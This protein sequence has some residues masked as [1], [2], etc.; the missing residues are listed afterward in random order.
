MVLR[1]AVAC[2]VLGSVLACAGQVRRFPLADPVWVDNDSRVFSDEPG[3]YY[4]G[5]IADGADQIIFRPLAYAWTFE[6]E[7]DAWN[8]NAVDEVPNSAWFTNRIGMFSM[9][10]EEA[11]RGACQDTP[12]LSPSQAP[13]V[14]T[15]A[16]PNGANP[17]FFIK[18]AN[19]QRYL[20]KFDGPVQPPRGTAADVIGS[21]FY[22]AAGFFTPCNE[23]VYFDPRILQIDPEATSENIFGEDEPITTA[24]IDKVLSKGFRLKNGLI[25][26]SASRFLPG[27]PLGPF[28]YEST[29]SDDPNDVIPHDNRRELRGVRLLAAMLNHFDSREQNSLDVWMKKK[30]ADRG[31]IRHYYIDW[32]DSF[33]GR[34]SVDSMSRR[35][36]H[37]YYFDSEH[38]FT[39]WLTLGMVPRP[40]HRVSINEEAE[41]FGYYSAKEFVPSEWRA[42][43]GNPAFDRMTGRDAM[44]MVRILSRITDDHIRAMVKTG[45]LPSA[46][47]E[48]YLVQT[49]IDRRD[50]I[51]AEYLTRF[52]PLARF[53]LAR[54]QPNN[55]RQSL[56]FEDLAVRHR[57]VDPKQ[58][59]YKMRFWGGER[60]DQE[61]GWLQFEPDPEHPHR[62][63]VV[64][65][66]GY[67]RPHDLAPEGA[68]ADH[69]LRYGVL[70]IF[71]HQKPSV[72]PT[73][74]VRLHFYDRGPRDGFVMVGV[75]PM[76]EPVTPDLY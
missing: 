73:S 16:K 50:A 22:Y 57:V 58:V 60:L 64:L 13:W 59:L 32:G 70:E 72:P 42:G 36:G 74:S 4:S 71:I 51:F 1:H 14:V 61:I 63:C 49:L 35:M 76:P 2:W 3:S 11:A 56:C 5:L 10:P 34:Q 33:G 44:W 52:S 39:D 66:L 41:I 31:Y 25:R 53:R 46:R 30:G 43:Y 38:V 15:A 21:K 55:R 17:G 26:A 12:P 18:A 9:T 54:R 68:P 28:R 19:G 65:P 37:S 23:I 75:E 29:R 24:D 62:S 40:W 6:L 47:S 8:V 69:P 67:R 27:R 48:D 20:L 7:R 45:K